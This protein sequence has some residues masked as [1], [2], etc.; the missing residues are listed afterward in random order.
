M[1]YAAPIIDDEELTLRTISRSLRQDGLE[2]FTALSGEDGLKL[3]HD[4][5]PD[6]VLRI[7]FFRASM[8]W[9]FCARSNRVIRMQ[10]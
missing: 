4:E 8:E 2:V 6:I 1:P 10:S 9:K 3:F 5:E 7:L